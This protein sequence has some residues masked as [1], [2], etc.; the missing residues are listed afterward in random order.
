[1]KRK[2]VDTPDPPRL[3]TRQQT[4]MHRSIVDYDQQMQG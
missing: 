3:T 4:L 1:M 2:D